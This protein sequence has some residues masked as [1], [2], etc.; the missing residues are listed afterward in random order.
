[1]AKKTLTQ[2]Y[3]R[4]HLDYSPETGELR[5]KVRKN[6]RTV[7]VAVGSSDTD[8]YT[9]TTIDR[10]IY[11]NHRII[12]L[13]VYGYFP[14]N[15]IDHINRVRSDNRLS[16]LR[17]VSRICNQRN[18]GLDPRNKSGVKGVCWETRYGKWKSTINVD[19]K[20]KFLGR[21]EDF[22]EAVAHRLAAE[23]CLDWAGCDSN[24]SAYQ[25]MK[26]VGVI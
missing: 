20:E 1:M 17:E 24:S 12:W 22:T 5:W 14:E 6:G 19:H 25:Y 23:Q 15:Q 16:N 2:E 21:F 4:Q 26:R 13:W 8:N 9:T 11:L 7:G 10:K 18:C 3:V